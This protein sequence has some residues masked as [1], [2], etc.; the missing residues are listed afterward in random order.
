MKNP[1]GISK[2]IGLNPVPDVHTYNTST[3]VSQLHQ[4]VS[5]EE[6][7]QFNLQNISA[8]TPP[9][10]KN[11]ENILEDFKKLKWSCMRISK[12]PVVHIYN[13]KVKTNMLLIWACLDGEDVYENL[14]LPLSQQYNLEAVFEAFE[15]SFEPTC[16]F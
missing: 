1:V 2:R 5:P 10:W 6:N 9:K 7:N 14:K 16:H 12:G 8:P 13:D 3:P 4:P 11:N 15:R